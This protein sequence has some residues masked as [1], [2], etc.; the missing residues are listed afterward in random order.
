MEG[1]GGA[2]FGGFIVLAFATFF[3]GAAIVG[4]IWYF[5]KKDYIKSDSRITPELRLTTDGTTIDTI[6][7]Y[8]AVNKK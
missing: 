2:I 5:T 8:R 3:A 4:G 6:Y 1:I 7:I